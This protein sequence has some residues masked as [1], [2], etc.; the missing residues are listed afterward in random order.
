[1]GNTQD[2][3]WYCVDFEFFLVADKQMTSAE[4][5]GLKEGQ[6]K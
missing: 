5:H 1:M 3:V 6:M 2:P 4:G